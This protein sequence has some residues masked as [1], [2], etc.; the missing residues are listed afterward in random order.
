MGHGVAVPV[1]SIPCIS[2]PDLLARC[3]ASIDFPVGR[4]VVIDNSPTGGYAEVVDRAVP[5]CVNDWHVT[6]P[7]ANLGVAASWNLA[8]RT[9]PDAA[10][11]CIANADTEFAPGDLAR[12]A[13]EMEKGGAR[14]VGMNGDWRV[15]GITPE[16]I[17]RVGWFDENYHPV[18]CED[19]DYER[20]CSLL[21]IPWYTIP[22]GAT[23]VGSATIA[24]PR[25]GS[26]NARTYPANVA[27]HRSKWGG[28]PRREVFTTPFDLGGSVADWRLD[29]RRLRD[30]T[31]EVR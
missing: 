15:F 7:P 13:A 2:R 24:D 28:G 21:G 23:H 10:W 18:Y 22:G 25:Y 1:L 20:R 16:V 26:Q 30:N 11:W 27:Y 19:A 12:L 8:I 31:W 3:I 4:L 14:W 6:V 9:A 29:I 17:E 5:G